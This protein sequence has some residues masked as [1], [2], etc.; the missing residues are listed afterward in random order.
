MKDQTH[1]KSQLRQQPERDERAKPAT[2]EPRTDSMQSTRQQTQA[3]RR[4]ATQDNG[5]KQRPAHRQ[6]LSCPGAREGV[7][8]TGL[9]Y[10]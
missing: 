8:R 6:R 5:T 3:A 9:I 1:L 7:G 2:D 10:F 4:L